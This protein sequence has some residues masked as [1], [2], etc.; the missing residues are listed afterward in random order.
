MV[1]ISTP[2]HT[3]GKGL[4]GEG[5]GGEGVGE[6]LYQTIFYVLDWSCIHVLHSGERF[7]IRIFTVLA[8]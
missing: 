3:P 8:T 7:V 6:K 5:G 2:I 1:Y 4:A